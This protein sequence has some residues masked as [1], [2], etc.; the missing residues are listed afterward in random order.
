MDNPD[1]ISERSAESDRTAVVHEEIDSVWLYLSRPGDARPDVAC[2]ALNTP[3]APP[4]P[5][6]ALYREKS[7]PPPLPAARVAGTLPDPH[8]GRW[9]LRWANDGHAVAA[10]LDGQPI[11]FVIG[12]RQRGYARYVAAGADPW[13]LPWDSELFAATFG[14]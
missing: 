7:G 11:A 1:I 6:F 5:D 3:E 10:L 8:D 14:G 12:G 4:L 9:S 2:W 13:A